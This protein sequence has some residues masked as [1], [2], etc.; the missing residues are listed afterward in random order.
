[1]SFFPERHPHYLIAKKFGEWQ[2][3]D[4][5]RSLRRQL[6]GKNPGNMRKPLHGKRKLLFPGALWQVLL[7]FLSWVLRWKPALSSGSLRFWLSKGYACDTDKLTRVHKKYPQVISYALFQIVKLLLK[8]VL[9][10]G[11]RL[12]LGRSFLILRIFLV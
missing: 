2:Q 6:Q 4:E 10:I 8:T 12:Q 1:M 9:Y 7:V 5:T 3:R 11:L